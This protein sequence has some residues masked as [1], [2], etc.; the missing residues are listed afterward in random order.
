MPKPK[1]DETQRNQLQRFVEAAHE[2]GCDDNEENFREVM[3]RVAKA[4]PKDEKGKEP[5]RGQT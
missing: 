5:T 1:A 3:R 2:L 4:K